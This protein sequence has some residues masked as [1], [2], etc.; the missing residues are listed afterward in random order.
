EKSSILTDV[1]VL[2][3]GVTTHPASKF[4]FTVSLVIQVDLILNLYTEWGDPISRLLTL[5]EFI[6]LWNGVLGFM[7]SKESKSMLNFVRQHFK[8]HK[9][10]D[11]T[12]IKE[13][14][15]FE[16]RDKKVLKYNKVVSILLTYT[17][18]IT[19]GL[20]PYIMILISLLKSHQKGENFKNLPQILHLY[21]PKAFDTSLVFQLIYQ[22]S[23]YVWYGLLLY[24][25]TIIGKGVFFSFTCLATEIN[26]F[27][28]KMERIDEFNE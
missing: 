20:V 8:K 14:E 12:S 17:L 11:K 15:M 27:C 23:I 2:K 10:D 1:Q 25:W 5:K 28:Y 4:F 7:S 19:C 24:Y 9:T 26:L 13:K 21:F 3:S 16:D 22:T 6:L 18:H